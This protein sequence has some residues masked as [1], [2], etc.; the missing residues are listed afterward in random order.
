MARFQS[1]SDKKAYYKNQEQKVK[2][3][4]QDLSQMQG[5]I[6]STDQNR[7]RNALKEAYNFL[8]E[9][10]ESIYPDLKKTETGEREPEQA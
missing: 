3:D 4:N 6:I 10:C 7:E 9:Y 2:I 1:K 5:F 8:N